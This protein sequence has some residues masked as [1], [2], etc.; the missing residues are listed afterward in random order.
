[1]SELNPLELEFFIP[2]E[3][4]LQIVL[5]EANRIFVFLPLEMS[6]ETKIAIVQ[7]KLQHFINQLSYLI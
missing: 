1:M 6:V 4:D 7:Y 2:H 5:N 3:M